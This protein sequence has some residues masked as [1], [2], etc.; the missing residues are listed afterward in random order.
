MELQKAKKAGKTKGNNIGPVYTEQAQP[1]LQT[2]FQPDRRYWEREPG[3]RKEAGA[4][5]GKSVSEAHSGDQEEESGQ[6][7]RL[8]P[9]WV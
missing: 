4:L 2:A 1:K 7:Y 5:D 9:L 6:R 8:E 3:F